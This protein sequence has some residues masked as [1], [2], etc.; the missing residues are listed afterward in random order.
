MPQ[1]GR[2][3]DGRYPPRITRQ[4][5]YDLK[6]ETRIEPFPMKLSLPGGEGEKKDAESRKKKE[7]VLWAVTSF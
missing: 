2:Q 3:G 6:K 4:K 7:K 5:T 1:V